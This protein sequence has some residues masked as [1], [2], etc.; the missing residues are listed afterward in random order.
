MSQSASYLL[1]AYYATM[2]KGKCK[3]EGLGEDVPLG[4]E[5]A[6]P[7][8]L[9]VHANFK[10]ILWTRCNRGRSTAPLINQQPHYLLRPACGCPAFRAPAILSINPAFSLK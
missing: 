4:T 8:I 7:F 5:S 1:E 2:P 9:L 10:C 3:V 6:L